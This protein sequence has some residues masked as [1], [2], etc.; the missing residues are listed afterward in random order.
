MA[1]AGD[2]TKLVVIGTKQMRKNKLTEEN[3]LKV[4]VDGN[5]VYATHSEKL[6]G[7][8]VNSE[9]TICMEKSGEIRT[10]LLVCYHS[11]QSG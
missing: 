8:I 3:K 6:L 2:K 11:F 10:I 9:M 7:L 4:T 1:C 5:E